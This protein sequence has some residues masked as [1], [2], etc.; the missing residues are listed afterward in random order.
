MLCQ[1]LIGRDDSTTI[2]HFEELHKKEYLPDIIKLGCQK[3][4]FNGHFFPLRLQKEIHFLSPKEVINRE[5]E[6]YSII[7]IKLVENVRFFVVSAAL[8][9]KISILQ[10]RLQFGNSVRFIVLSHGEYDVCYFSNDFLISVRA[11]NLR[12]AKLKK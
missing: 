7:L 11:V 2:S 10:N 3:P 5:N 12:A 9:E 8:F 6:I 1:A 4:E